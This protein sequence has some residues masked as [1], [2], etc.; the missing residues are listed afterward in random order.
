MAEGGLSTGDALMPVTTD[1]NDLEVS[2]LRTFLAVARN[3]S[4]G[5]TAAVVAKTQPAVSQQ[6]Q[7]LEKIIGR[8]LFYRNRD[9]VTLTSHGE[10]LAAYASRAIELND[11][12][13]TRLRDESACEPLCLGVSEVMSL[14]GLTVALKQFQKTHPDVELKLMV[15]APQKLAFLL[16]KG[17]L[18]F[19]IADST[20]IPDRPVL[21][22]RSRL[23]WL[24][25]IDLLIDPF[26]P[27]PLVLCQSTNCWHDEILFSLRQ[28]GWQ[29]RVVFESTS[30]EA[31]IA[32]LDSG[33][34]ISALLPETVS[35]AR[36]REVKYA[37]LPV[38]PEVRFGM[39]R[40]RSEPTRARALMETALVSSLQGVTDNHL[41]HSAEIQAWPA[42]DSNLRILKSL[43]QLGTVLL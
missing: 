29:W 30:V 43:Q 9:G 1:R 18:D 6:M 28:A 39:F 31:T 41:P 3:G 26:E 21:E 35:N 40:S 34:G 42:D 27:L 13:L 16:E 12:V 33:M 22:W 20:Q 2:L 37:R 23:A 10:L 32:A 5:R 8:K 17:E 4:M 11:E 19:V 36:L 25:S 7:R 38:L 14:V 24:A 15:A